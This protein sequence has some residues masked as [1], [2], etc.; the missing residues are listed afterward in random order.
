MICEGL[1]RKGEGEREE[2][3]DT[4]THVCAWVMHHVVLCGFDNL[5]VHVLH[6]MYMY[7]YAINNSTCTCT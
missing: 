6:T 4:Y 3:S 2:R 1:E 7:M 5:H